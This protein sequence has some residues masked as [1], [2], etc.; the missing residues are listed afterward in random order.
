MSGIKPF[1]LVKYINAVIFVGMLSSCAG[2]LNGP[3]T[4]V[5]ERASKPSTNKKQDPV[6]HDT[7]T[8]IT[9]APAQKNGDFVLDI[10]LPFANSFSFAPNGVSRKN[11]E[12]FM[13]INLGLSYFYKDNQFLTVSAREITDFPIPVPASLFRSGEYETVNSVNISASNNHLINRWSVG[14]GVSYA[15]NT[16]RLINAKGVAYFNEQYISTSEGRM[17]VAKK[18]NTWGLLLS[19]H[20]RVGQAFYIGLVYSPS[21]IRYNTADSFNYE[22]TLSLDLSWRIKLPKANQ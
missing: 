5:S 4:L 13:G 21:F 22:H 11:R 12:G 14:Y 10:S 8:P 7:L 18:W 17:P 9:Y 2:M 6:L 3:L 19:S 16:W 20:Y 15:S 1:Y